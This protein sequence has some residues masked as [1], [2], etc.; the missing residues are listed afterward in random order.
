MGTEIVTQ[1]D[2]EMFRIRLLDDLKRMIPQTTTPNEG[3]DWIKSAEVRKLLNASPGTLQNLRIC[4]KLHPVKIAGSWYY[5]R[6]E[7]AGLFNKSK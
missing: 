3:T 4:G 2:L 6:T 5:S 1:E 7:I